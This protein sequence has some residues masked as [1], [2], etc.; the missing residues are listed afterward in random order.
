MININDKAEQLKVLEQNLNIYKES[1]REV[2]LEILNNKVS[3]YPVFVAYTETI[4]I[5][6]MIIDKEELALEYSINASLL[7]EFV[8]KNIVLADKINEFK[9]TWK[10]PRKFA[11]IFAIIDK[12]ASF[13]YIPYD[14]DQE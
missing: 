6:K 4:T 2:A 7:E 3:K 10:D 5:G 14:D 8:A 1:I 12:E 11:C 13:I 9:K